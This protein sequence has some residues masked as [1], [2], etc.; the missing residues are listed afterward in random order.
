LQQT[1]AAKQFMVL[2]CLF[3]CKRKSG[4]EP[5]AARPRLVFGGRAPA[6]GRGADWNIRE[7]EG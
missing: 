4:A 2:V 3:R 6:S 5:S 1:A 7:R